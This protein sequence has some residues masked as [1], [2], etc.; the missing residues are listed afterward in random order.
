MAT[1]TDE[2]PSLDGGGPPVSPESL[3]ELVMERG[4]PL[5]EFEPG[6]RISV[7]DSMAA[8]SGMPERY[9]YTLDAPP[10]V[11][12]DP[13][14]EPAFTPGEMLAAGVFSGKY[15]N[16]CYREFPQEWFLDALE[17]DKLRPGKADPS[18]NEFGV[19]SR[20]SVQYWRTKGWIPV[21]AGD[22]DP[23]G[24]FQWYC[25][26]WIGRRMPEVDETQIKRW[27]AFRRHAGQIE[28]SYRRLGDA[29]P[30]TRAQKRTHR[31][32]QRQG[33]LQWAYDPWI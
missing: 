23:R 5:E 14:F 27:K 29:A 2:K 24:W 9:S 15:L 20:K 6:L 28:A 4:R 30:R 31:A 19:K 11:D 21:V 8:A 12:F 7:R 22:R 33:L 26:Y 3:R 1:Y 18:V 25:R 10:G 32:R 17:A 16:D 13:E